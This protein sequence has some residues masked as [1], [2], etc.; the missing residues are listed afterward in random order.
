MQALSIC[1]VVANGELKGSS[2]ELAVLEAAELI[3]AA[4]GGANALVSLGIYPHVLVGDLDSVTPDVL[5]A[6]EQHGCEVLHYSPI[7]DET[8]TELALIEAVRRGAR[9]IVLLG[10][11]GG[12]IDHALANLML[13]SLPALEGRHVRIYDGRSSCYLAHSLTIVDGAVGDVVSLIPLAGAAIGIVTS[14]LLYA[15]SGDTLTYGAARGVS[16]ELT[17]PRAT[18]ET[19]SGTLLVVHTPAERCDARVTPG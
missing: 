19:G 15:L 17:E 8:D 5:A 10:A 18:I 3:I 9:E 6:C 16:N 2:G 7:K 11:L 14:G 12:R 1:A 13:L 4:D